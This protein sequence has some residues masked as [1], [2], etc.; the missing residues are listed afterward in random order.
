MHKI[1]LISLATCLSALAILPASA[2]SAG[3]PGR[4]RELSR[5]WCASCHIVALGEGR[6]ATDAVPT[7]MSVAAMPSTTALS[8]RVFLQT[9][10]LRMPNFALTA[11]QTD[12]AIAYIL[13]LRR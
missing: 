2:Q 10:H 5:Q 13:S 4:G 9:P 11:E 6:S 3:D 1:G 7:F 12:D 8:L